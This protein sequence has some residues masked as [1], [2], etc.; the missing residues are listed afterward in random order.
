[1]RVLC[2]D[3]AKA[4]QF[5]ST[6]ALEYLS[7]HGI[8]ADLVTEERVSD[9]IKEDL[10]EYASFHRAGL[11]VMGGYGHSRAGEFLFGGVTRGV[12]RACPVSLLMSR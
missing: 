5:P 3:E 1:V 8:H 12:L 11:I 4:G 2:I 7:R 10:V 6:R 9:S